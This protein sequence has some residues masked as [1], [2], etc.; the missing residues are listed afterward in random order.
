MEL[1][2]NVY[3]NG[4]QDVSMRLDATNGCVMLNNA[5]HITAPCDS[6]K[7][8]GLLYVAADSIVDGH[9]LLT[10]LKR[11][12]NVIIESGGFNYSHG[13]IDCSEAD[14]IYIGYNCLQHST[15]E[16]MVCHKLIL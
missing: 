13:V 14:E 2:G 3:I 16:R 6:I 12:T 7:P 10:G 11:N 5:K 15:V 9:L 8:I 1:K 4:A